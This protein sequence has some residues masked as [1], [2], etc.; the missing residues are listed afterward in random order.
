V[1]DAR[2]TLAG[3]VD[4]A[5]G[6]GAEGAAGDV[7]AS[8]VEGVVDTVVDEGVEAVAA[9]AGVEDVV[10][11]VV[12]TDAA[13]PPPPPPPQADRVPAMPRI[14]LNRSVRLKFRFTVVSRKR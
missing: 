2:S 4:D 11:A 6:A 13:A 9:G 3:A 14:A 5:V 8:V 12:D 7:G 10:D 1:A